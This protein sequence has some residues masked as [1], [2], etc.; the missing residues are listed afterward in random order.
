MFNE[1]QTNGVPKTVCF[2]DAAKWYARN[3]LHNFTFYTLGTVGNPEHLNLTL[4]AADND[5]VRALKLNGESY[6][7]KERWSFQIA[8]NDGFPFIAWKIPYRFFGG[9]KRQFDGYF[10]RRPSGSIGAKF[11][12]AVKFAETR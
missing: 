5:G 6:V 12:P 10:G 9:T 2:K 7:F 1:D 3:P 11:R 4:F 8:I